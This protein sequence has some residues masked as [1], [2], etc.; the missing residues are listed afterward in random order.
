MKPPSLLQ[1]MFQ[2]R[3]LLARLFAA[4]VA[5]GAT[6][7]AGAQSAD[8]FGA[9]T[10]KGAGSTFV[11]PLMD[12]WAREFRMFRTGGVAIARAGGGLDDDVDGVALDYEA[13]GSMAGIQRVRMNAVDFAA[14]E[15]PLPA[16]DLR[17]SGLL[18][19]PLVAGAV[20]VVVNLPALAGRDLKLDAPTLAAIFRG[21]IK[22]WSDAAIAR[23]NPGLELPPSP[24]AVLHRDDGSGT[25][26]TFTGYLAALDADW[27]RDI[28]SD[29]LVNWPEGEG[30][31]GSAALGRAVA[32]T[33]GAISYLNQSQAQAAKLGM[34]TLRNRDGRFVAPSANAV[35]AAMAA[36]PWDSADRFDRSLLDL[37]GEA[38]WPIVAMV[39]GISRH[40]ASDGRSR[41]VRGFFDWALTQGRSAAERLG[42]VPL[43]ANAVPLVQ[44]ALR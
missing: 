3:L 18:Q 27:K 20:A 16:A 41:R 19:V 43:P 32:R 9:A 12:Q 22:I 36:V 35:R 42:Y 40:P 29:L 14:T 1:H 21:R 23:Q 26:Y 24:I 39:F 37:P 8:E 6:R 4:T 7:I 31:K 5:G 2:R 17:T 13:V 44:A 10:L 30:A 34:A 25:T 28:G 38:S 15:M 11:H 33:P